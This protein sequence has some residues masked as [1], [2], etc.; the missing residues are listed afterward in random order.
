M[1]AIAG[2]REGPRESTRGIPRAGAA[3]KERTQQR[4]GISPDSEEKF[5]RK[6]QKKNSE[7]KNSEK[8]NYGLEQQQI[9]YQ[10]D[11][12]KVQVVSAVMVDYECDIL[13]AAAIFTQNGK[14]V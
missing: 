12:E 13:T 9:C 11:Q 1:A 5:R 3:I 6:V 7:E 8:K 14:A 2:L 4:G 10:E